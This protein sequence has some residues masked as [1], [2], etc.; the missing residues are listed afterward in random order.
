[1]DV[2]A[3]AERAV[4]L[5]GN[6]CVRTRVSKQLDRF[7]QETDIHVATTFMGKGAI[8]DRDP[9]SLFAAG[10]GQRDHV[11]EVFEE[12]DTVLAIGYDFVEWLPEQWNTG[13][14]KQIIHLDFQPSEVD[15]DYRAAVEVVGDLGNAL[16]QINEGLTEDH[17]DLGWDT[18]RKV[19]EKLEYELLEEFADDD[20]FPVKPQRAVADVRAVLDDDDVLISDVGA[21]KMWVARHY[22]TYVANTCIISN[23]FCSM[24]I[25]LPGAIGAQLVR[26]DNHVVGLMGDGGFLMNVQE[27]DT[28]RQHGVAPTYVVWD[29][30][31]YGLIAWKQEV[32]FGRTSGT[33]M[34]HHDLVAVAEGFGAHA[35]RIEAADELQPAL[36]EAL[37][38]DDRPSVVVVPVDASE[39]M[40]LSERLGEV[41]AR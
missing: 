14:D 27:L 32:E 7:V 25:A 12:A 41:I 10:L 20:S 3:D 33:D 28:A 11:M 15:A 40:R 9:H 13:V 16:W 1:L 39:N 6:G 37:A 22:P 30:S 21:H 23:G 2:L 8:S 24:G 31:S 26:P 35:T 34:P 17:R 36:R 5:A 19:R 29:D 4:V 18:P 38:V